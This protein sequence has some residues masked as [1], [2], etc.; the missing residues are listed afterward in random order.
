MKEAD[1]VGVLPTAGVRAGGAVCKL[2]N[3]GPDSMV[4]SVMAATQRNSMPLS[5]L[6]FSGR[7]VG[8]ATTRRSAQR[9]SSSIGQFPAAR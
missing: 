5:V 6:L 4:Q 3:A 1:D 8:E 7:M 9:I 2:T